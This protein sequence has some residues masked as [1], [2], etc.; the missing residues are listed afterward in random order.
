MKTTIK[1]FSLFIVLGLLSS[2]D[3]LLGELG[4]G[5]ASISMSYSGDAKGEYKSLDLVSVAAVSGDLLTITTASAS[6]S[7]SAASFVI[8]IPVKIEKGTYDIAAIKKQ[9]GTSFSFGEATKAGEDVQAFTINQQVGTDFS[10]TI[11]KNEAGEIT[12]TFAGKMLGGKAND[13]DEK[14]REI[15][16]TKGKFS[17]KY[18][19]E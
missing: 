14:V 1:I 10:Y 4:L 11:T 9:Q 16:V 2:C 12:G 6:T 8:I 13:K 19:T 15:T 18:E 7:G 5:K 17:A 3:A